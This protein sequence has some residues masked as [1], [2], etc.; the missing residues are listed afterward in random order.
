MSVFSS[1]PLAES[2]AVT[3]PTA[4]SRHESMPAKVRR[5]RSAIVALY[6][7]MYDCGTSSGLCTAWKA[8]YMKSGAEWLC[9]SMTRIAES[10]KTCVE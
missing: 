8:R 6:G 4:S 7:S 2:A 1:K 10:A 5:L 3:L 9:A